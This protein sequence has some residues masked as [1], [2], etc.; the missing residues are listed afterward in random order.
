MAELALAARVLLAAV[1]LVA[2]AA[3]LRDGAGTRRA[4][5]ELGGVP[6]AAAAPVAL[7]LPLAELAI[8]AVLL[9]A[10][11]ASAG[12]VA[13][14]ALLALFTAAVAVSLARGQTPACNCFGQIHAE[15]IG[16]ATLARNAVL[17]ALAAFALTGAASAHTISATAWIGRLGDAGLAAFVAGAAVAV[18]A[19]LGAAVIMSVLKRYGQVLLRVERLE[20]TLAEHGVELDNDE[21]ELEVRAGVAPGTAAPAA[22]RLEPLLAPGL[23][24]LLIFASTTC[25][26]CRALV[27]D[28]AEWQRDH[29]GELTV[30]FA[31]DGPAQEVAAEYR[32]LEHVVVDGDRELYRAFRASGTPSAVLVGTDGRVASWVAAGASRIERLLDGVLDGGEPGLPIGAQLPELELPTL[33]GE[34][35]ALRDLRGRDAMLLF[36]NP[37]CGYCRSMRED[38]RRLERQD[39]RL[40]VVS[41]GAP[42]RVR[43]E[44]F[45]ALVLLDDGFAAA[46]ALGASGTPMAL[47]VDAEGRVASPVVAGARAVLALAGSENP[48]QTPRGRIVSTRSSGPSTQ[49]VA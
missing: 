48:P 37:G 29:A 36:W 40:V 39:A 47:R 35:L 2:A 34:T 3:K 30:A 9:P 15:P 20:R 42:E 17:I 21:F 18:I 27:P 32:G 49:E 41:A 5:T 22:E 28:A 25:G 19:A 13:A 8:V 38:V 26:P 7:A 44:G 6:P 12:A 43:E 4:V 24:L 14:L 46:G 10:A 16:T 33:D 23:P 45:D 11:T 31:V 1:F